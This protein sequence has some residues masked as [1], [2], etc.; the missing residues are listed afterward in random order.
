[1][2]TEQWH[3]AYRRSTT[4]A[5]HGAFVVGLRDGVAPSIFGP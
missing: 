2:R 3:E 1:M 5:E 4:D